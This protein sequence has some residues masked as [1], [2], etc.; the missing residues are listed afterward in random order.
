MDQITDAEVRLGTCIQHTASGVRKHDKKKTL[1]NRLSGNGKVNAIRIMDPN[2]PNA[3]NLTCEVHD[4]LGRGEKSVLLQVRWWKGPR[5]LPDLG[6]PQVPR[7]VEKRAYFV[8]FTFRGPLVAPIIQRNRWVPYK[9]DYEPRRASVS[10]LCLLSPKEHYGVVGTD[11]LVPTEDSKTAWLTEVSSSLFRRQ[12]SYCV[13]L[14]PT[15]EPD[16]LIVEKLYIAYVDEQLQLVNTKTSVA[17]SLPVATAFELTWRQCADRNVE[18]LLYCGLWSIY[19]PNLQSLQE[20]ERTGKNTPPPP[21]EQLELE[22][23]ATFDALFP[24]WLQHYQSCEAFDDLVSALNEIEQAPMLVNFCVALDQKLLRESYSFHMWVKGRKRVLKPLPQIVYDQLVGLIPSM[25]GIATG[26]AME[27]TVLKDGAIDIITSLAETGTEV[28]KESEEAVQ[29]FLE[30]TSLDDIEKT[31]KEKTRTTLMMKARLYFSRLLL[32]SQLVRAKREKIR[33]RVKGISLLIVDLCIGIVFSFWIAAMIGAIVG[34]KGLAVPFVSFMLSAMLFTVNKLLDFILD[35][36]TKREQ[37]ETLPAVAY[38]ANRNVMAYY[39]RPYDPT[40]MMQSSASPMFFL[41]M[42]RRFRALMVGTPVA[43]DVDLSNPAEAQR[44]LAEVTATHALPSIKKKSTKSQNA[45]NTVLDIMRKRASDAVEALLLKR[46]QFREKLVELSQ[47]KEE[48]MRKRDVLTEKMKRLE[49]ILNRHMAKYQN[50]QAEAFQRLKEK[51]RTLTIFGIEITVLSDVEADV[52]DYQN[53][54]VALQRE[55]AEGQD[56][57]I[58]TT[59]Q[60]SENELRERMK[61]LEEEE[62]MFS[63]DTQKV[64]EA[65]KALSASEADVKQKQAAVNNEEKAYHFSSGEDDLLLT[66]LIDYYKLTE[67]PQARNAPDRSRRSKLLKQPVSYKSVERCLEHGDTYDTIIRRVSSSPQ[68]AHLSRTSSGSAEAELEQGLSRL[69]IRRDSRISLPEVERWCSVL[70]IG[71][72]NRVL[73][74]VPEVLPGGPHPSSD[75][76]S[77]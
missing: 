23:N 29:E 14:L 44:V 31:F 71:L 15:T 62:A 77:T 50:L 7:R 28:C 65:K 13:P 70:P 73:A 21:K 59:I 39:L 48:L 26:F 68:H 41:R 63:K 22:R 20:I 10:Y 40:C 4:F 56:E 58:R 69:R 5:R 42:K 35:Y 11:F 51:T 61:E 8:T 27:L 53:E 43:D 19:R 67:Y 9:I 47:R 36:L 37:G 30:S 54:L 1:G 17:W 60:C 64:E 32:N 66:T 57:E 12:V 49:D 55:M 45:G 75:G 74:T 52:Q 34:T 24:V 6:Q 33:Q 72:R 76:P 18:S 2:A 38:D 16:P 25:I 3:P 46:Q